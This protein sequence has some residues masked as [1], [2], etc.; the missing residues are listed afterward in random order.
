MISVAQWVFVALIISLAVTFVV[1]KIF[2]AKK[3]NENSCPT[4]G[5][6]EISELCKKKGKTRKINDNAKKIAE[7]KN[8]D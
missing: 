5:E 1:G 6:C 8:C 7:D 4:C 3:K 2:S